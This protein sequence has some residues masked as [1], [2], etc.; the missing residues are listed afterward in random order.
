MFVF[1]QSPSDQDLTDLQAR[2]GVSFR[3]EALLLQALTHPSW[4]EE[5]AL[6]GPSQTHQ[7][8]A[9]LVEIGGAALVEV[10]NRY[11]RRAHPKA[12]EHGL[13]RVAASYTRGGWADWCGRGLGL[14]TLLRVGRSVA[15]LPSYKTEPVERTLKAVLGALSA[16]G[17][18]DAVERLISGW[19]VA[20]RPS[21][22]E[23]RISTPCSNVMGAVSERLFSWHLKGGVKVDLKRHGP[24]HCPTWQLSYDLT[25]VGLWVYVGSG[26]RIQHAKSNAYDAIFRDAVLY[27]LIR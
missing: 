13:R 9:P 11:L 14:N 7:S 15:T 17:Q 18:D 3:D 19:F 2:L 12:V 27:G 24:H 8:Q 6:F 5:D 20:C 10:V 26:S 16:D 23:I 25:A 4:V 21:P 22:E 1:P